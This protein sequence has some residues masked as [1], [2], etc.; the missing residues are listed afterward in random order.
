MKLLRELQDALSSAI[1]NEGKIVSSS[2]NTFTV[3]TKRGSM[4]VE[5]QA[6]DVT[7]YSL[8]D[9]VKLQSNF[10]LGKTPNLK[11]SIRYPLG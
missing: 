3:S 7:R 1:I 2:T 11:N 6:G 9:S 10:L 8:G 5:R 4:V